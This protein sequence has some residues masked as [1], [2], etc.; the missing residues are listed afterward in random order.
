MSPS[1]DG[2][3]FSKTL[4]VNT[5]SEDRDA[6]NKSYVDTETEKNKI[7]LYLVLLLKQ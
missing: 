2:V 6:A 3:T 7:L 4:K 1:A 5:P